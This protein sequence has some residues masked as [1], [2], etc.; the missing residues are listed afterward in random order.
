MEKTLDIL[1]MG[2]VA[3]D[4][5]GEQ[6]G[7][8]LEDVSSFA[9][10]VGGSPG[11]VS[12]GTS[13]LGLKSGMLSRVGDE[14]L[15]RFVRETLVQEGVDDSQLKT[16]RDHLTALAILSVKDQETFPLVFYRHDCADMQISEEDIDE[17]A[18]AKSKGLLL[19]G[20]HLS[21]EKTLTAIRRAIS[22]AKKHDT[23][24]VL[25][26]DYR[27]VLWGLTSLGEGENRFVKAGNVT[28]VIQSIV[29]D[30]DLIVG[31]EEEIH[32]AGGNT[33]SIEAL[34][35]L[36]QQSKA[37]LVIKRGPLGCSA[38][39]GA[40]PATLD[41]GVTGDGV[42]VDV[43][44]VLGAGDAFMSGFLAG[45]I[46]QKPLP[47]CCLYAN[48]CGAIVVSRHGCA[49][50]MP[51]E[52]ELDYF[53]EHRSSI[54]RPDL[55]QQIQH[56]HRVTTR[57][58]TWNSVYALAFDHRRQFVDMAQDA[59]AP[60]SKISELKQLLVDALTQ[61]TQKPALKGKLGVLIDDV[62]GQEQ[63]NKATG[64]GLW[65]G[66]PVELPKSRPLVY[67]CGPNIGLNIKDWPKEQVVKCLVFY[68]PDDHMTLRLQQEESIKELYKA[69]TKTGHELLLEIIPPEGTE[70]GDSALI[71]TMN[72][73]YN[74][75]IKPD[76]WK[77]QAPKDESTWATLEST[78]KT[79]DPFCRGILLLGLDAPMEELTK[80]FRMATNQSVCKGFAVGRSLFGEASRQWLRGNLDDEGFK[81]EVTARYLS[82]I[83]IWE[84][85]KPG[86]DR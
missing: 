2:R 84:S 61:L 60:L 11:N 18:I 16:D 59:G 44:N 66:R 39:E 26:I 42:K 8:R 72:R 35:A 47:E 32:I 40:I 43:L 7:S 41:E 82:L 65:I 64:Q 52:V 51:T 27:P 25:D 31:T 68:H 20:T 15:G 70:D 54:K 77:V 33:D 76:W 38:F 71:R 63:L 37:L 36:R 48:A 75:G 19:S 83:E 81:N 74:L 49:P 21:T 34:R 12:I 67:E 10:Y 1:C 22:F 23:K 79:R 86:E 46:R 24:V 53:L 55:D 3:V 29:A 45:W 62:F 73:L 58:G 17:E 5:Y 56:L 57:K 78:I 13:R 50:A 9:K 6:I 14:H 30:C 28:D 80:A 85:V 4:L 69:C